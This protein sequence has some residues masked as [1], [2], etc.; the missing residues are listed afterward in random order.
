[1]NPSSAKLVLELHVFRSPRYRS[2][3][4]EAVDFFNKTPVHSLPPPERFAG[5]GV[6]AL[7][8]LGRFQAYS[9]V[10]RLTSP[11][12]VL[13]IYV[14][15]AVPKGWRTGRSV[16][17]DEPELYRRLS[18]HQRSIQEATNLRVKDFRC[19]FMVLR[20]EEADLVVPTEAELIREFSPLWN[21]TVSGFGIHHPGG[22]RYGQAPSEWDV[23]HPGRSFVR[24]LTGRAAKVRDITAE[25]AATYATQKLF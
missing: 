1:M 21:S 17:S 7:Y 25:I 16:T 22:G 6:Y 12:F 13:P 15:K 18:E 20:E 5:S 11:D 23:L 2:V 10:P 8:Y 3:V 9:S 14:G 4:R 24:K 19:R